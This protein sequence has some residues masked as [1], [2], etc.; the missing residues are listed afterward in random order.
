[1]DSTKVLLQIFDYLNVFS[2]I[3][4]TKSL[5]YLEASIERNSNDKALDDDSYGKREHQLTYFTVLFWSRGKSLKRE[6]E[7]SDR[8]FNIQVTR[9]VVKP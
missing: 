2:I 7:E 9:K 1:M 6:V 8:S 3:E 4:L 5:K